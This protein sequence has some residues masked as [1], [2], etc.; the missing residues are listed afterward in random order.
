MPE[1]RVRKMFFPALRGENENMF[2]NCE[3]EELRWM[4]K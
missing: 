2:V 1:K 3:I 4:E